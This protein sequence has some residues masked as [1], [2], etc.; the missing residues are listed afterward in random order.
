MASA[1][2]DCLLA[3]RAL[4]TASSSSYSAVERPVQH[5]ATH[6]RAVKERG[7]KQRGAQFT[8]AARRLPINNLTTRASVNDAVA[9]D[10]QEADF[11]IS[12]D[13]PKPVV[14][15]DHVT[16]PHHTVITIA[17]GDR[18][19]A[20]LDTVAA[21]EH[22]RGRNVFYVTN[23]Y[24]EKLHD[25]DKLEQIRQTIINNML[26]YHP[27]SSKNL[28]KS[29]PARKTATDIPTMISVSMHPDGTCSI[30]KVQTADRP[31]LLF[32]ITKTL[33]EISVNILTAEI[34]TKGLVAMDK[35]EVEYRGRGLP[36]PM[37]ELVTNCLQYYL[38]LTD[39]ESE[40]SY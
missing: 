39:I 1:V 14:M 9:T 18:L 31:G 19:G 38:D 12:A 32:D 22:A 16:D 40:E 2:A 33:K 17:F 37:V 4:A 13:D 10:A 36:K 34:D 6:M 28:S 29:K 27:E 3:C 20:L 7:F 30:L 11:T 25:V 24:G 8:S 26:K 23:L 35:F 15:I 5:A 21:M